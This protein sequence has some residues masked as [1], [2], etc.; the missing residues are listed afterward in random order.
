MRPI[1]GSAATSAMGM[2]RR[3]VGRTCRGRVPAD[4]GGLWIDKTVAE[5]LNEKD[6]DELRSGFTIE[7]FNMRGT[8]G[9]TH[10]AE[11]RKIAAGL[12]AKA[13]AV[14]NVTYHRFAAA[15]RDLAKQ[16][17]AAAERDAAR[18]PLE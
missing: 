10:G 15:L 13:D 8:H 2:A 14:E 3:T 12:R 9:F 6:A 11:E 1:K 5:A 18:N 17:E 4:P 16:Y 7:L